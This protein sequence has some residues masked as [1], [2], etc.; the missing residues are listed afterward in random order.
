[1][2]AMKM[3]NEDVID[4]LSPEFISLQLK[5]SGFTTIYQVVLAFYVN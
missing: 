1:M 5:L 4:P 2:V 3:R